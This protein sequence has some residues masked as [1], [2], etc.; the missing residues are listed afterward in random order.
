MELDMKKPLFLILVLIL[1]LSASGGLAAQEEEVSLFAQPSPT[2]EA[3]VS[4]DTDSP[5]VIPEPT[6]QAVQQQADGSVIVT[7]SAVGD[8]TFGGDV[9]KGGMSLFDKELKKQGGDLGFVTRNVRDLLA[10]DDMT[11]ANFETTLTS[12]LVFKKGN[13][14]VFSAP[15]EYVEI[16]TQGSIEAV[17]FENNHALDHGQAGIDETTANFD[18]HGIIWSAEGHPGV[19]EAQGVKICLLAYQTFNNQYPRLYDLVPLDIARA[20]TQCDIVIVSYHWGDELD[21]APNANQ[22]K[23]GRLTID[24]GADLVVGHHSHRINPIEEYNGKYIVYSLANFSFAGNNKPSDMSSFVFQ[25]RFLVK[26][27]LTTGQGFRI[28]PMRI[29]SKSDYN[30]FI[31]TPFSD[32]RLID[33]VINTMLSNGKRLEYAVTS[34]PVDWE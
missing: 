29:S 28:I 26:D 27:G 17:S 5:D 24:A 21:Y 31:P 23:L 13:E 12:A 6:Q 2:P 16:L 34:Y 19:F 20:K 3:T 30:D 18:E 7:I 8:L 4:P 10:E 33:N 22:Q 32:Q 15:P 11:F 1:L 9:R 25:M 14:F